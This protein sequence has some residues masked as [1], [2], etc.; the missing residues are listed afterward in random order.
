MNIIRLLV[1]LSL[2]LL[3]SNSHA[4]IT[5]IAVASNMKDAFIAIQHEF[6]KNNKADFRVVYGS[7][8][9]IS[10]QIL[11]GAPFSL[12]ISADEAYPLELFKRKVALDEGQVYAI[13]EIAL[14]INTSKG[15]ALSTSKASIANAIQKANKIAIAKPELAPYGKAAVDY[16]KAEGLWDKAKNKLVYGDN[17]S[18][19]SMYVASGAADIGITA[20]SLALSPDIAK[21][22]QYLALNPASYEP[23]KQRMI[24]LKNPPP[25]ATALYQFMQSPKA[26]AILRTFGYQIP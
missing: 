24:L 2:A 21:E 3:F 6:K 9:N 18:V 20:L 5:T 19:A 13:G 7:S 26:Q 16:L 25:T 8:G 17:I 10:A 22:T 14:L 4:Q 1:A 11:N 15:I 12:F 23:I